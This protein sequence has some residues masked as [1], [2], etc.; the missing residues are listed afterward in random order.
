MKR[1]SICER[2]D[3]ETRPLGECG[4][5]VCFICLDLPEV[6]QVA[7][8]N[9]ASSIYAA[10]IVSPSGMVTIDGEAVRPMTPND[11]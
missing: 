1:C 8:S 4:Q 9:L 11:L 6:R 2:Q 3:V 7:A 5:D 10:S